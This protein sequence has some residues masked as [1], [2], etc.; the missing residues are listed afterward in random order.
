MRYIFVIILALLNMACVLAQTSSVSTQGTDTKV[1]YSVVPFSFSART[2]YDTSI[3]KTVIEEIDRYLAEVNTI[4][5][6]MDTSTTKMD[7]TNADNNLPQSQV[8]T[9]ADETIYDFVDKMP[10]FPGGKSEMSVY[11]S[12][13]VKYPLEAKE[14]GAQGRVICEFIVNTDG[15]ISDVKVVRS[16]GYYFLDNEAIR[17]V[18]S[19][20]KWNP[21]AKNGQ[22]VRVRYTIPVNFRLD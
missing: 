14:I 19:M 8:I 22:P 10:E 5:T 21:G 16:G 4:I 17:V 6:T 15:S 12:K 7:N 1:L 13:N 18:A 9:N 20:P 11:L 3:V 2:D